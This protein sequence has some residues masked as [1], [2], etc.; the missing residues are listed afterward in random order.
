M[1]TSGKL[2]ASTYSHACECYK[3]RFC[4]QHLLVTYYMKLSIPIY[5]RKLWMKFSGGIYN[6]QWFEGEGYVSSTSIEFV[7]INDE[8]EE[9]I[10]IK[11]E[12]DPDIHSV[13]KNNVQLSSKSQTIIKALVSHNI[14]YESYKTSMTMYNVTLY[15]FIFHMK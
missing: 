8:E 10:D 3:I 12:S 6:V 11:Y 7:Y 9:N 5:A 14:L 15:I 13:M 2:A 1:G 4:K